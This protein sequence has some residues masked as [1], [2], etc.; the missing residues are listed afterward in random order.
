MAELKAIL[1][2]NDFKVLLTTTGR[3]P[4]NPSRNVI[5]LVLIEN[6]YSEPLVNEVSF[7]M[8][9]SNE[10]MFNVTYYPSLGKYGYEKLTVV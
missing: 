2:Y 5:E 7:S 1:E 6:G 10:K 8:V 4:N 9:D 3:L